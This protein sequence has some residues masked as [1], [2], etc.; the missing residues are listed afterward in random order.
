M[1]ASRLF[2]PA[3]LNPDGAD[4]REEVESLRDRI[5]L[6]RVHDEQE[7][8]SRMPSRA[9]EP[10]GVLGGRLAADL[11]FHSDHPVLAFEEVDLVLYILV[12]RLGSL[13]D[14]VAADADHRD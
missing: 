5:A 4:R 6:V 2:K 9:Y 11:E 3:D 1:P 7:V 13:G 14:V 12:L 8:V 10:R